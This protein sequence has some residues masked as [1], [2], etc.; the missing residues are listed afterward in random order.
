[1]IEHGRAAIDV[2][3][4]APDEYVRKVDAE[5]EQMIWTHPGMTTYYRNSRGRVFS[6][7]PWRF[8]DYWQMTHDVDLAD[9]KQT[10]A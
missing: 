1:M 2:R 6:A 10:K 7:M 4:E 8:V 3:P 9:Y 5:H